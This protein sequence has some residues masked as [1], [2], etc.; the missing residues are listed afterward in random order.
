M[1]LVLDPA[2]SKESINEV[3]EVRGTLVE[4]STTESV[5]EEVV[6]TSMFTATGGAMVMG[7]TLGKLL[8]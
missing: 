3:S 5:D 6:I 4:G 1:F 2:P 8:G 7:A